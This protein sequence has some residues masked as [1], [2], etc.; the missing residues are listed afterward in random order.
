[1]EEEKTL[2]RQRTGGHIGHS[3]LKKNPEG[4][5][6]RVFQVISESETQIGR[7]GVRKEWK[8]GQARR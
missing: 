3:G 1:M 4:L 5:M 7:D 8:I 6:S 2:D